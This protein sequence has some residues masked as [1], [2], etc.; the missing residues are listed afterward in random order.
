MLECIEVCATSMLLFMKLAF[1]CDPRNTCGDGILAW[2]AVP[3][4][5]WQ[6]R[7]ATTRGY[8]K[9]FHFGDSEK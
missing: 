2:C 5:C 7:T 3:D 9:A 6:Y 1:F 8:G 4:F